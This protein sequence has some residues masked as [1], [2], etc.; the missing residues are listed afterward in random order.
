MAC[1][2]IQPLRF[3]DRHGAAPLAMTI[4]E[5]DRLSSQGLGITLRHAQGERHL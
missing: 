2:A 4:M 5:G 3:L 1:E